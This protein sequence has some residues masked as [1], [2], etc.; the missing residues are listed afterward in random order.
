[1][2]N[3][4]TLLIALLGCALLVAVAVWWGLRA[5]QTSTVEK[6]GAALVATPPAHHADLTLEAQVFLG[7]RV[8]GRTGRDLEPASLLS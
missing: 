1:M 3:S 7:P 2:R 5:D 6:P 4:S 8:F